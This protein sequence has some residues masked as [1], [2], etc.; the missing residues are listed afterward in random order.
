MFKNMKLGIKLL[1]AFLLVGIIPFA[2]AAVISMTQSSR[3]LSEK[4]FNQLEAVREI[5]KAQIERFFSERR[6]D[7]GV[8][9]E[10]VGSYYQSAFDKLASIQS[11][12]KTA[13][14][15][16]TRQW[17]VDIRSQQNR[18]ICTKGMEQ[19]ETYLKLGTKSPEYLRYEGI[20]KE[21]ISTT[22]YYD[23]FVINQSGHCVYSHAKEADYDTNLL[24]GRYNTSGLGRA[25]KKAM[26]GQVVLEDFSSY[27][28]SNGQQAAFLAAPII[29]QK[30][31]IGVV[32]MQVNMTDLLEI[33]SDRSG[34]GETG[35]S[36]LVGK[37]GD[38]TSFRSN[39]TTMGNGQYVIG[40]EIHTDYIDMALNGEK[41]RGVFTDSSGN[42]TMVSFTPLN[43][44]GV[45]W[46]LVSK[47]DLR[48]V[49]APKTKGEEKDYFSK[50]VDQYG[51]FDLFLI[52]PQGNVFYTVSREADFGTNMVDGKY[53]DSG[54]GKLVRIV[55]QTKRFGMADF[56]PYAPS[57]GEP[58]AFIAQ[59]FMED[60][61]V[62]MI[63]GLQLSLD[64]INAIM[65]QR[66]GMGETGET[67]LVGGDKLMRSDSFLDPTYHS[68]KASFA[69]P[70]KGQVD[71]E[72]ARLALAGETGARI[73]Q[74][75]N[76]NPVLSAFAPIQVEGT[77][78]A[79]LAEIDKAEAFAA[80]RH[81][82]WI[83]AVLAI[84]CIAAITGLSLLISGGIT[85]PIYR[86]IQ[87]LN[88]GAEQVA[89]AAGQVASSSQS[90][91]EG[92]SEQAASVEET[93]S[94]MEQ[95]SSMTRQ[96][97]DNA[98]QA[99]SLM[100][101]ANRIVSQANTSMDSLTTSM[102]EISKA[103]EETSKIIKTIDE[104]AFQTNLLAL[105]AAVEAARAGEAGAG[106]AVVADEVRN[107][108][109]RAAEAAKNTAGLIE[110]TVKRVKEGSDI[111]SQTSQAFNGVAESAA[112]VGGLVSEIASASSEQA[113]GITQVNTAVNEV[114]KITQQNAANA[115]E[116][117]S[118]SE[119]M[120][121]QAEQ[122][123]AFVNE[124]VVLIGG[125]GNGDR[126]TLLKTHGK[127][128]GKKNGHA[129]QPQRKA[130][131]KE[132]VILPA[133]EQR[134][135]RKPE[136]VIPLDDD[137]KDF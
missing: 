44:A 58:A 33:V 124:L 109:L 89:S 130:S 127:G 85:K 123:R 91:A 64:A 66:E 2:V 105:N 92:A 8:L 57:N 133:L 29:L 136:Q 53:A 76:G 39:M 67:Y 99:D 30:R 83:T 61:D 15:L 129:H 14:E 111:V 104:I 20:I 101:E 35:E 37:V 38:K 128:S 80:V 103:G 23:F 125:S 71:T 52:H 42:L 5:K 106:F 47:I 70:Q 110:G 116:S 36:Y 107:L 117:A 97:A 34:M 28:P 82:Q 86:I 7:M 18:S 65:T 87:G 122:M 73:I 46:A 69:N 59:P 126:Q 115:E 112:K 98:N 120:S 74:D 95:M 96:N 90:L 63:I 27:A 13:L 102:S 24:T 119:E 113:Q 21:F 84:I 134:N 26:S 17:F 32:A 118:A 72:A 60:K 56:A 10:T 19:Y 100:K 4:A 132:H 114:D 135:N 25:V 31:Q 121:A 1:I 22:G 81:M 51:Y 41:G 12:K 40:H 77:T 68:V 9:M 79:L 50:Y 55:L 45:Y 78:W 75:Y 11:N 16:L 49:M 108:A 93:S 48:E 6:G 131:R 54:L 62:K 43:I 3:A 88:E 94:S 137:F